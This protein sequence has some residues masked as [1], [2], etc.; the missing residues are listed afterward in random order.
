MRF[1][2]DGLNARLLAC[3]IMAVFTFCASAEAQKFD[4]GEYLKKKDTNRNGRIDPDEMSDSTRGF[5][6]KMGFDHSKSVSISKILAKASNDKKEAKARS[7][8]TSR[9]RKVPGFGVE[10]ESSSGS[11]S[12]FGSS[13]STSSSK[14]SKSSKYSDSV[15]RQVDDSLRK[16]DRNKD[17]SLDRSEIKAARWGSPPP[18]QSDSNRDGRLSKSEL[19]NRYA[20]REQY[21][22]SSR[23]R[24]SRSSSDRD[25]EMAKR[26]EYEDRA[27]REKERERDRYR[28]SGSSS[29]SSSSRPSYS[30]SSTSSS[31]KSSPAKSS[32]S[33]AKYEKYAESLIN[34]YDGDKNGKLS[35][36]ETKKMRRPPAGA[37][38]DKDGFITKSELVASLSGANKA[39]TSA[40]PS[41][42][43]GGESKSSRYSRD[44][45]SKSF[46]SSRPSTSSSFEKTRCQHR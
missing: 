8:Q 46:G 21:Y 14:S 7:S 28:S 25:R 27:R 38:T 24:G 45:G 20:S 3:S 41:S 26:K 18:E 32:D 9:E 30:R 5:L 22:S 2:F 10:K 42:S 44:R 19:A 31:S 40:K 1:L 4:F 17:G 34:Q 33:Q 12:R 43:S 36:E 6:R 35:R 15:K 29:T 16:Y 23:D 37:D 39:T 11:G 13:T